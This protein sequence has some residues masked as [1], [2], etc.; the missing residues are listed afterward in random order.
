MGSV[1]WYRTSTR[2]AHRR[3]ASATDGVG[4]HQASRRGLAGDLKE[5]LEKL[6]FRKL[7]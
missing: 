5:K 7:C 4:S 1:D 3:N 2:T 6:F